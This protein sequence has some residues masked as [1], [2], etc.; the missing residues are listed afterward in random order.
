MNG[1]TLGFEATLWAAADPLRGKLD[2]GE[3]KHVVLG[4]IFLKHISDAFE[5]RRLE[6][7]PAFSSRVRWSWS[8][9]WLRWGLTHSTETRAT[10][11]SAMSR[12][13]PR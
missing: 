12:P 6:L 13:T 8:S 5:A 9:H 1:T 10:P 4:L 2:P 3:Y 11:S 7:E